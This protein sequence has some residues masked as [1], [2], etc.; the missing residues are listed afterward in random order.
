MINFNKKNKNQKYKIRFRNEPA[1]LIESFTANGYTAQ[2]VVYDAVALYDFIIRE[3]VKGNSIGA[4]SQDGKSM[5]TASTKILDDLKNAP[6]W[7]KEY[8]NNT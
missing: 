5:N 2:D 7:L 3:Q 8:C 4:L 1:K 6:D